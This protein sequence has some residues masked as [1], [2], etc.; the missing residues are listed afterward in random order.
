[1]PLHEE[2]MEVNCLAQGEQTSLGGF[3][4]Y[5]SSL[6]IWLSNNRLTDSKPLPHRVLIEQDLGEARMLSLFSL[7][8]V[9]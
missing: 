4:F 3:M 9:P 6:P 8:A 5:F 7:K 2:T 1:M